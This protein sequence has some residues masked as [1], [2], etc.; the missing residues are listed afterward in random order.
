MEAITLINDFAAWPAKPWF[1][2]AVA[3]PAVVAALALVYAR[4]SIT[5]LDVIAVV[6]SVVL[7]VAISAILALVFGIGTITGLG[8]ADLHI[9]PAY[10]L[11]AAA[12]FLAK[13]GRAKTSMQDLIPAFPKAFGLTF[14]QMLAADIIGAVVM[15]SPLLH[16]YHVGGAGLDDGLIWAPLLVAVA[17]LAIR[18]A[19]VARYLVIVRK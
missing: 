9:L 4:T 16:V 14:V 19:D 6:A 10:P 13:N 15:S 11:V 18:M 8:V 7:S 5:K 17:A 3:A 12:L 1:M 2:V